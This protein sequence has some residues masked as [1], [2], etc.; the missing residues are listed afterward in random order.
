MLIK[1]LLMDLVHT[2]KWEK[3]KKKKNDTASEF[4]WTIHETEEGGMQTHIIKI[5]N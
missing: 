5:W 4:K 2:E 3:Q 1:L